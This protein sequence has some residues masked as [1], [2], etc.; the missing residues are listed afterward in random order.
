MTL[1][2]SEFTLAGKKK[3]PSRNLI[4]SW[5]KATWAEIPAEMLRKPFKTCG[6][7]NVLDGTQDDAVFTEES[8]E[9]EDDDIEENELKTDREDETHNE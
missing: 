7:S 8:P 6:I 1:W 4:L 3:A 2:Q 9:I 5:I